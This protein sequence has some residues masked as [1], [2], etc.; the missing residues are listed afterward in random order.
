VS[1]V[2]VISLWVVAYVKVLSQY[3]SGGTEENH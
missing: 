2:I 1:A 3:L